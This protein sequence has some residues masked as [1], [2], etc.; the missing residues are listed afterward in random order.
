VWHLHKFHLEHR[1]SKRPDISAP[2]DDR[3]LLTPSLAGAVGNLL[4]WYDSGLYGLFAPIFAQLFF[5]GQDRI[6]SLLPARLS[7][8][9]R[10][11][12]SSLWLEGINPRHFRLCAKL[13]A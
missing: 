7:S 8:A 13:L 4:E 3:V 10:Q 9:A 11:Q 2:R 12:R 5:P 6:A 1:S